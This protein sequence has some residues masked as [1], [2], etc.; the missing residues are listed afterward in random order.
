MRL[1]LERVSPL[2]HSLFFENID[3]IATPLPPAALFRVDAPFGVRKGRGETLTRITNYENQILQKKKKK[4][5]QTNKE[6][7][8]CVPCVLRMCIPCIND[9]VVANGYD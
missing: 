6:L 1:G 2:F 8:V 3:V 4:S 5:E 9:L 7:G